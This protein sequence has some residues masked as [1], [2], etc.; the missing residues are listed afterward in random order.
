MISP[1]TESKALRKGLILSSLLV[2]ISFNCLAQLPTITVISPLRAME[3]M[4]VVIS[5]DSFTGTSAVTFGGV[6]ATSFTVNSDNY[7][8]AIVGAGASGEVA[9]TTP[10]G[11]GKKTGFIFGGVVIT[12]FSPA[13]G[14]PGTVVT[15]TGS[16]FV[17]LSSVY[18]GQARVTSR[19]T[20]SP[21]SMTVTVPSGG[22]GLVTITTQDGYSGFSDAF[23]YQSPVTAITSVWPNVG[24]VGATV[25]INGSGF[26]QATAVTFGGVP[27]ASYTVNSSYS[28][29]ATV[30]GGASGDVTVTSPLGN[31]V[32]GGFTYTS[33]PV[34]TRFLPEAAL[35]GTTITITGA[36]FNPSAAAN[37]VYFGGL[38][39]EVLTASERLLTVKVPAGAPYS[40]ISVTSNGLTGYSQKKFNTIFVATV[41]LSANSFETKIDSVWGTSPR[42]VNAADFDL[43]GKPDVAVCH[44]SGYINADH[45]AIFKNSS[46][47]GKLSFLPKELINN[48]SGP[49]TSVTGDLDGDGKLDLMVANA[50]DG[51]NLS[52]YRNASTGNSISFEKEILLPFTGP[53]GNYVACTDVDADGKPDVIV[54]ASYGSDAYVY[55]NTSII[56]KL[57]FVKV[58]VAVPFFVS[59]FTVADMD[60]DGKPDFIMLAQTNIPPNRGVTLRNVSTSGNIAFEAA[61]PFQT[62]PDPGYLAV[63]DLDGDGKMDILVPGGNSKNTISIIRNLSIPGKIVMDNR[64][65]LVT[66]GTPG[67]V[68]IGD[69]NGD[70]K[71]DILAASA[72]RLAIYPSTSS[73]GNFS[74]SNKIE[75]NTTAP[76]GSICISDLDSDQRP[77]IIV[78]NKEAGSIS[79]FRNKLSALVVTSF[80]PGSG[81]TGTV[82]TIKGENFTGATSVSFGGV[83]ASSFTVNSDSTITAIVG[84]GASGVV[85]V[86]TPLGRG[87]RD[88]FIYDRLTAIVDPGNANSA[89]LTV[90]PN[91]AHDVLIIK[92]PAS[93]K[94]ARLRFIDITGRTVKMIVP[95]QDATQT[96]TSV[97]GLS[98]GI[99][100]IVWSE[101]FR[102]L[103]RVMAVQ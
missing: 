3:G 86:T 58:A 42:H 27:A 32:Y 61:Q 78:S 56:G 38:K 99:Y 15:I 53:N 74:F 103:S 39:A 22:S 25:S 84:V 69:I 7:I 17:N 31:A 87:T 24:F 6:P 72:G 85:M 40:Y 30:A 49:L 100:I 55:R 19:T 98:A 47:A 62:G 76:V 75:L 18:F 21:T 10:A 48:A 20:N 66:T 90:Q 67:S 71:P 11:T 89:A 93:V 59:D 37:I 36:N 64:R 43:D 44:T 70:G 2:C 52:V 4:A 73:P 1:T 82:V 94:R 16:G 95:A 45:I 46:I 9:V 28:I 97:N 33:A 60:L 57:S 96:V 65:D 14:A 102:T 54:V 26:S 34:I 23:V 80:S 88:G 29:T 12:G 81:S 77:D 5:G 68:A 83:A 41:P 35:S 8:T 79:F 101:G 13:A 91:P 50:M 63:G 51:Q 92:H